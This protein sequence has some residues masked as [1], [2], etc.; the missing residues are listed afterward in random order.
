MMTKYRFFT[1]LAVLGIFLTASS[2]EEFEEMNL[3]PNEPT[4]VTPDV[5]LASAI[6]SSINTSVTES[7]LL[8]N[9]AAQLTAKTLR[10]EVDAYNWQSPFPTVWEGMYESLTDIDAV[11]RQAVEAG[12]PQLEGAALVMRVWMFSILTNA[13]GDIPYFDAFKGAEGNFN[14]SYTPQ[15][16]IYLDLLSELDRADDLL[17][18]EGS[19]TGDILFNN[20]ASKWRKLANSLHLRLIMTASNALPDAGSRFAQVFNA[21]NVMTDNLDNATLE[22]T[23]SFPNQYPLVPLKTGDFDAV[24]ISENLVTVMQENQDPRLF[25]YARPTN[26]EFNQ[27]GEFL[28]AVNGSNSA[29]CSK[30]GSR[31]GVQYYDVPGRTSLNDLGL[32]RAEGIIMTYA[33]VQFLIAEAAAKGWVSENAEARYRE[34]IRASMQYHE[35]DPSVFGWADFDDFYANSGVAYSQV[36][37]I[38]KQKWLAL[39]FHGLEPYFEVRRWYVE[40]GMDWAGIPFLSAPCENLNSDRLPMRF[41]YPGQEQSLNADNYQDAIE[42]LG[43][44]N[45]FNAMTWLVN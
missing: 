37:D 27:N 4:E 28:G 35:A 10:T 17:A 12:N 13:Y 30:A 41:R 42:R 25:R 7:F 22:Y 23:G 36:T 5:L 21:G 2:C 18:Q 32:G 26:D 39:Y 6:R 19:I 9:N 34:G 11:Q 24:A 3:N 15:E 40:S 14:P 8:G 44:S 29:N 45:D 38:W 33:E 43:G 31:L 20:D 16:E 1:Y